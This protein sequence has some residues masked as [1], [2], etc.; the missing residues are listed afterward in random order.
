M[1]PAR[2]P[3][4][5]PAP[6]PPIF[7]PETPAEPV[8]RGAHGF[9][10]P[11]HA[12]FPPIVIVAVT[13][14]CDMA[15]I[16]CAHPVIKRDPSYRATFM[17]PETHRLIVEQTRPWRDRLWVFRYAADG[18]SLLNPHF[19]DMV[20]E[21]KDAGIGP[22]DLTTNAMSLDEEKMRRLLQAP[23]DVID[24]SLDAYTRAAYERIRKRGNFDVVTANLRRLVELRDELG[25][26]TKIMTSIIR[27]KEAED[28][29]EAFQAH[30]GEIVDEVLVRGLN[31]DLGI[32]NVTETYFREDL[33]RWPCP[34]FWKRVTINHDGEI[35]FCVEDWRN[36]GVVG[37]L[38]ESTIAEIW[39]SALYQ[40]FRELHAGGRW[41]EM[42]MCAKCMDWQHMAWD[43]GFEKAVAR[44]LGR[45]AE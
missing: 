15:C 26:P 2:R 38:R 32:V 27:Q 8:A 44:V 33:V 4:P 11:E 17:T 7:A 12:E 13:N 45:P 16:H 42:S 19:L 37:N 40:R 28:E 29:V 36:H 23:V 24:V 41:N 30:W 18:E 5:A 20:E 14:V 10:R 21:T 1:S 43:H 34:Q 6:P 35:R 3:R 39:Q 31:T 22:V 25:S 9:V